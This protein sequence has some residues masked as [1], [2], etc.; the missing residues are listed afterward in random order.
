MPPAQ[1]WAR[2]HHGRGRIL[3]RRRECTMAIDRWA[4]FDSML[5]AR[6]AMNRFFQ[7]SLEGGEDSSGSGLG[8]FPIDIVDRGDHLEVR[9]TLPGCRPE[10]V[11]LDVS[12]GLLTIAAAS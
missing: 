11:Q 10:S 6:Y 7:Q 12:S 2:C 3:S 4:P 5:A 9:A 1:R 8:A